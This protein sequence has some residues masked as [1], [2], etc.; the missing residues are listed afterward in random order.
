[1]PTD[2]LDTLL[3]PCDR[4]LFAQT[5]VIMMPRFGALPPLPVGRRRYVAAAEGL[6][7]QARHHGLTLTLQQAAV[8]LPF[9]PLAE[10]VHL[11]GGLI[12]RALYEEIR[13]Q[14][15]AHSPQEWAGL[16]HWDSEAQRYALTE[17][18]VLTR[19]AQHIRY[20]GHAIE[21]ERLVLDVHSHGEGPAFF[22]DEDN[23]SDEF[24]FHFATVFGGCQSPETLTARTRLVIDG[25][26]F[27]IDWHPWEDG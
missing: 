5:P 13:A 3:H 7:V 24:G 18:R 21:R 1:M 27:D 8:S 20:D 14:V 4:I 15:L 17:P 22:S 2:T 26:F 11:V 16:V 9:G 6:Y 10:D 19:S 23:R 12:P 25:A